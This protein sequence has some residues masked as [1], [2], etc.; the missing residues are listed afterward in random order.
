M[1][2]ESRLKD[3]LAGRL[4]GK[5]LLLLAGDRVLVANHRRVFH[6]GTEIGGVTTLR[7]R[8]ELEELLRELGSVR[9]LT[10]AMRAQAHEFA[11]RLHTLSGLLQLGHEQEALA[12][13]REIAHADASLRDAV[14]ERIADPLVGA[15]LLAKSAVA[16]ERGVELQMAEDSHLEAELRDPRAL[17]TVLGNLIDNAL[18][19]A[20]TAATSRRSLRC[21]S[22]S[23]AT[24]C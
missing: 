20:R 17:L 23:R 2:G 22:S 14:T 1:P 16:A 6:E 12:F 10:E 18:D 4:T 3:V 8:T 9:D 7:D 15:L 21:A 19:A 24:T 13:I 5:D 11:N